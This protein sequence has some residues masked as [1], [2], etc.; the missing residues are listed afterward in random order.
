MIVKINQL[1]ICLICLLMATLAACQESSDT[2]EQEKEEE[3]RES[4]L[5]DLGAL[6]LSVK[7]PAD[8][9]STP[10]KIE[11]GRL[12]FYDPIL[13]GNKD[14]AC[15]SCHHP[16]FG[17]AE[18]LEI[19]IGVNGHGF[20]GKRAFRLPNDIPFTKRNSQTILNTAF[21]GI[22]SDG[23]YDPSRAPMFWDL[24]KTSLE[25]QALEPIKTL[26]EMRGQSYE[27]DSVLAE[28]INRLRAFPEYQKLFKEAFGGDDAVSEENLGKA[29]AAFERSLVTPNSR[30]DQ[31]MRGD[32]TALSDFEQR[33]LKLFLKAGCATCHSGPMFSDY[34]L[35][36]LGVPDNENLLES[37][38]GPDG[39]Y[40]FRTPT[41]RNLRFTAPY[42]HSGKLSSLRKVMEFYED[43]T[44][45]PPRNPH[46]KKEQI[47]PLARQLKLDFKDL[48]LI[49]EFLNSLNDP[50]FDRK[51]PDRVP[52][53][54]P[55]GG[56]IHE[57]K[58]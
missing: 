5:A 31:Y 1:T 47:D 9:P 28:V 48:R 43:I 15:A 58:G 7:S 35:H 41:L 45:K 17:Y 44:G 56:N 39:G 55:V 3:K 53:G 8:N 40:A 13:S 29:L 36:T 6:P 46:V 2:Q 11:L 12:L 18:S 42:M 30:F 25:A 4:T 54:L 22:T 21:N 24:R 37:D 10:E 57:K 19:S 20:G 23:K 33:G 26:E 50:D 38:I 51:M 32:K 49:E 27:T 16:E 14:V 52:S 34:K